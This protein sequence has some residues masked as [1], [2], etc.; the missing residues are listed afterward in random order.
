[1]LL[2]TLPRRRRWA[3][4]LAVFLSI[5]ALTAVGCGGNTSTSGGSGGGGTGGTSNAQ[6]GTYSFTITAV[7]G[8]LV[9]SAQVT[10]K[11]P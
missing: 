10:V 11:V 3:G 4:L 1:M 6:S 8:S 2:L 9:H 5:A 7:S